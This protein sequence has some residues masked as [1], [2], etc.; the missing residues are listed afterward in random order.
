M[1]LMIPLAFALPECQRETKLADI[2]C[3]QYSSWFP[4]SCSSYGIGVFNET[5]QSIQNLTWSNSIPLCS[6]TFN[7]STT[8]TY[9]WNSSI[10]SGV[11]TLVG[12]DDMASFTV[13]GFLALVNIVLFLL[14][15]FVRFSFFKDGIM[16]D[17]IDY[18][19]K[20]A[21]WMISILLFWFIFLMVAEVGVRQNL[22]LN[23]PL[24]TLVIVFTLGLLIMMGWLLISMIRVPL[25]MWNN[26]L[27]Q[28]RLGEIPN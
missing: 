11:I 1:C 19:T 15:F 21:F 6:F 25:K 26:Y 22:G 7:I 17:I 5:N 12:G 2:P 16:G 13:I 4:G 24:D 14:P 10:D 27:R 28:Q 18:I 9:V 3:I 8:G 23:E 20:R